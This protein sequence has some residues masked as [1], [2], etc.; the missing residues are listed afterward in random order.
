NRAN[1]PFYPVDPRGLVV[2]ESAIRAPLPLDV[3]LAV[4]RQRETTLRTLAEAT[5]GLAVVGSNDLAAG[6]KRVVDDLSSY[7]LMGFYSTGKLDGQFHRITVRVKRPG[8]QVRARRGYLAATAAS[9]AAPAATK[10]AASMPAKA[11]AETAAVAAAIAPL[12]GYARN[13]PMRLQIAAGSKPGDT[14]SA[15]VWLAGEIG[16]V[17]TVG[18]TWSEGFDVTATLTTIADATVAAGRM[19]VTRGARTFRMGLTPSEPLGPGDYIL[20]VAARAGPS[21]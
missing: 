12:S 2:F 13:V 20:R 8:V 11:S 4:T 6:L 15:A 16:D 10:A 5:D 7:Y 9:A 19:S 21:S 1:A 3:D 18:E 14:A 17:A